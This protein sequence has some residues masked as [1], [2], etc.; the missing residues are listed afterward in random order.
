MTERKQHQSMF[1]KEFDQKEFDQLPLMARS[2]LL[3]ESKRLYAIR[4]LPDKTT[5]SW[6]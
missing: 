2:I 5:H 6:I 1:Q 4:E 3:D